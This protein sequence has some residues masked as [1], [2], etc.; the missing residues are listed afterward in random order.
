MTVPLYKLPSNPVQNS[1]WDKFDDI[2]QRFI[3]LTT[4]HVVVDPFDQA[5]TIKWGTICQLNSQYATQCRNKTF[6]VSVLQHLIDTFIT[7]SSAE[8]TDYLIWILKRTGVNLLHGAKAARTNDSFPLSDIKHLIAT[9]I[10]SNK[11]IKRHIAA[12]DKTRFEHTSQV[13]YALGK[14]FGR[15]TS[16]LFLGIHIEKESDQERAKIIDKY[17]HVET[18]KFGENVK[19]LKYMFTGLH[20]FN[21]P[22]GMWDVSNV[23]N[24]EGCFADIR[25]FNQPI[26]HW[27]VSNVTNMKDTFRYAMTFNQPIGDWDV[28]KVDTMSGLFYQAEQFNQDLSQWNTLNLTRC[29][30]MFGLAYSFNQPLSKFN[31][32]RVNNLSYMFNLAV[33]FNQP[34]DHLDV[35]NVTDMSNMFDDAHSFSQ[36]LHTW[37]VSRVQNMNCMFMDAKT[38]NGDI[39]T[40]KPL[41][42]IT[43]NSMFRRASEFNQSL[44]NWPVESIK[45]IEDMFRGAVSF[46]LSNISTWMDR[47][48]PD[49]S[50]NNAFLVDDEYLEND[51]SD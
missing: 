51:D 42:L 21:E 7:R 28:T 25:M 18:W 29:D 44:N 32:T 11:W 3:A 41:Q 39:T 47:L 45:S 30:M 17:G 12:R 19:T 6:L 15:T 8:N 20:E 27:N 23:E 5:V 13:Y 43:C 46:E 37:N 38:F 22:I 9:A 26:G 31:T 1:D 10:H 35:S 14:L 50:S 48:S 2:I 33:N 36:D 34:L 24:L 4:P 49:I 40:W 16:P